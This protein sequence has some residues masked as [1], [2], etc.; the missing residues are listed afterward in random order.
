MAIKSNPSTEWQS[1]AIKS[2]QEQSIDGVAIKSNQEQS[3]A[4]TSIHRLSGM[5]RGAQRPPRATTW[6]SI[7]PARSYCQ[8]W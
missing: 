2:N 4:I 5:D 6:H 8:G 3:R 7:S 1:K